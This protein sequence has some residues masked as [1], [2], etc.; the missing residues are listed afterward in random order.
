V[1]KLTLLTRAQAETRRQNGQDIVV[2]G[3]DDLDNRPLA[4]D[5]EAAAGPWLHHRADP[6]TTGPRALPHF[7]QRRPPPRGHSS[8]ETAT[9]KAI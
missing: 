6:A 2:C 1:Q 9:N 8:Y 3:P 7:Q 4:A 5:L